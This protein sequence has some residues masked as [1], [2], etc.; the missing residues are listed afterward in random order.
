MKGG[1]FGLTSVVHKLP[2]LNDLCKLRLDLL[3]LRQILV[4]D[5]G[6]LDLHDSKVFFILLRELSEPPCELCGLLRIEGF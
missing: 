4:L 3:Q 6:V 2:L 1:S 5:L